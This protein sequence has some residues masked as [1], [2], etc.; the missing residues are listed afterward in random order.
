M[1]LINCCSTGAVSGDGND[2]GGLIG[3][4]SGE[5]AD[6]FWDT[7][8]S[9]QTKSAGGAGLTT[10]EMQTTSIFLEA[11]WDFVDETDNG[12]EDIWSIC[13]GTNYPR[14]VWQIAACDFVCPDGIKID[15]F[16]FF[17]EHWLDDN[18]DLSNDYCE[19]TDLDQSGTVDENDLEI[20]LENWLAEK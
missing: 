18:C 7:Q 14:L 10:A 16:L 6:C 12:T 2:I 17:L 15:D 4:S 3:S 20:F 5:V 9:G 19:G 1:A 8:T 11:G 13:E